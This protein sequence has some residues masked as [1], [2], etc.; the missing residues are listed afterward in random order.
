MKC[1]LIRATTAAAAAAPLL[2]EGPVVQSI[3][4]TFISFT[5][6]SGLRWETGRTAAFTSDW[7]SDKQACDAVGP[8]IMTNWMGRCERFN[9]GGAF[10]HRHLLQCCCVT[11]RGVLPA[12]LLALSN[13]PLSLCKLWCGKRLIVWEPDGLIKRWGFS[14][15]RNKLKTPREWKEQSLNKKTFLLTDY[16]IQNNS[17][18]TPWGH[19]WV[20]NFSLDFF[21]VPDGEKILYFPYCE[22]IK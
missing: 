21:F 22:L 17:S 16:F 15:K 11:T 6:E 10:P 1:L 3:W 8:T 12:S 14:I 4:K 18:L 5:L 20:L 9:W 19:F 13:F 7:R 2:C